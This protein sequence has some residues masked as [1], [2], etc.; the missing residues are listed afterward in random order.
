MAG[1]AAAGAD[2]LRFHMLF[3]DG[4][5]VEGPEGSCCRPPALRWRMVMMTTLIFFRPQGSSA[6]PWSMSGSPLK[7]QVRNNLESQRRQ[8]ELIE[9][10]RRRGFRDIEVIDD[11]PGHP[12]RGSQVP[13]RRPLG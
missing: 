13:G 6:R 9:E 4:V 5:Y 12:V 1:V 3:L 8:Y 10:A 2:A 11:D 7:A